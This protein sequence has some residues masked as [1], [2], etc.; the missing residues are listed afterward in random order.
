V[1]RSSMLSQSSMKA[2]SVCY[3]SALHG[4]MQ[5]QRSASFAGQGDVLARHGKRLA[6]SKSWAQ[7]RA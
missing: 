1:I 7:V 6:T 5:S 4:D 3:S 2:R